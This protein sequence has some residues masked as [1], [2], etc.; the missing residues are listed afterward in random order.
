MRKVGGLFLSPK[1]K[2]EVTKNGKTEVNGKPH[3][4]FSGPRFFEIIVAVEKLSQLFT[5]F[6]LRRFQ[7]N[8]IQTVTQNVRLQQWTAIIQDRQASGL[9]VDDYCS[10]H[11]ISRNAYY[12][13]LRK[14]KAAAIENSG[15][16]FAEVNPSFQKMMPEHLESGCSPVSICLGDAVIH[17]NEDAS[18]CLLHMVIEAVRNAE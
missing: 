12:Y 8:D 9:K 15:N 6:K 7:M 11:N 2:K 5:L 17:V 13:W 16:L 4:F 10:E 3:T 18:S 1:S 14:V